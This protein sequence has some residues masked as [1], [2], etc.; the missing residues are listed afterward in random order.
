MNL[1]KLRLPHFVLIF[2]AMVTIMVASVDEEDWQRYLDQRCHNIN[3]FSE[4]LR[5]KTDQ[6]HSK[7]DVCVLKCSHLTTHYR[8]LIAIF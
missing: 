7:R 6:Y 1:T 2:V 4:M 8:Y 5:R 3:H